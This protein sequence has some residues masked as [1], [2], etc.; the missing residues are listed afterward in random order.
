MYLTALKYIPRIIKSSKLAWADNL[1]EIIDIV[2]EEQMT[3]IRNIE[4]NANTKL[5]KD[6]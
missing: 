5:K 3:K 2:K 1:K 6:K 4:Y